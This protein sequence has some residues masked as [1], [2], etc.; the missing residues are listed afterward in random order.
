[1]RM[2]RW[3]AQEHHESVGSTNVEALGDPRAGR[4]VVA[5]HQT[6]GLGR[7]GRSWESPPRTGLAVS[8]VVP[9]LPAAAMG[10]LPL[11]AGL[12][13]ARALEESRWTVTAGLKWPN[14]VLVPLRADAA[15]QAPVLEADGMRWGKIAGTLA[16]V[17]ERGTV[18]VGTGVNVD[19]TPDQLPV[20][21]ATSWRLARGGAPVPDGAREGLLQGYLD[22]LARAHDQLAGGDLPA[23]RA[24]YL[25]R[26]LTVGRRVMVLRPDGSRTT[27]TAVDLDPA[28]ALVLDGPGGRST[29]HA[30]DV[31]HA[32]TDLTDPDNLA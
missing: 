6:S 27:G 31:E 8:V 24:A 29:H 21:T 2:W 25:D 10:W 3:A 11:A 16:Q 12:A 30:G 7:L 14:D 4:V 13:L 32:R 5:D 17:S 19:H 15:G 26:S 9:A 23:V 28:G 22:H 18:V 1:M 20:P